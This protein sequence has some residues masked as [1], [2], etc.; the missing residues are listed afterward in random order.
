[1]AVD[2]EGLR[3]GALPAAR[4]AYATPSHQFPLGG[5]LSAGRRREL[6]AW[7]RRTGARVVEDDYD[8]E[9]R[10]DIAPI[11]RQRGL[12]SAPLKPPPG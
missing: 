5:V 10:F 4:L 11:P 8:S 7:A 2:R 6:L 9:Y 3:T 1:M 12:R